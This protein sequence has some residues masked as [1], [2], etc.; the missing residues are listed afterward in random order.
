MEEEFTRFRD[1]EFLTLK[2][3]VAAMETLKNVPCSVLPDFRA[4]QAGC[5][6][7][8]MLSHSNLPRES[9]DPKGWRGKSRSGKRD[10]NNH[11]DTEPSETSSS[12]EDGSSSSDDSAPRKG[13]RNKGKSVPGLEEIIPSRSDYKDLVSYRTYRLANRSNRYNA[14]VTGKMSTY[15]KRVKHAIAP[16][17]RFSG[18]E[19]IEVLAFLRTFKEAADHNELS[20]AAAARLLP[21][22]LTGAAKEGHRAHLDEAP[23]VFPTYPYMIQYLLETYAL[24]D[25]LSQAYVAITTAKQAENETERSFGRRLHRLAIRAGN[26]ID[27]QDLTTI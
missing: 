23:M 8:E 16:D 27:K 19:P 24:D 11:E 15:L 5:P 20:E 26:V 3:R 9:V 14:T 13:I 1:T 10:T 21:Y 6:K 25:E 4:T 12:P 22:F 7:Q 2:T 17:D 18:D